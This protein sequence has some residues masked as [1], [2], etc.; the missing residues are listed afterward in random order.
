MRYDRVTRWLHA[1][2]AL[3]ITAQLGL[4]LFMHAPDDK[5]SEPVTGLP[6]QLFEIHEITGLALLGVLLAHW[7]WSVSGHVQGGLRHLFPWFDE[8][9]LDAVKRDIR[10]ALALRPG[11]PATHNALAGAV[12][13]LGLLLATAMAASGTVIYFNLSAS[14]HLSALA[15]VFL[16][17]HSLLAPV[18]WVYL[19]GHVAMAAIHKWQGHAAI[20]EI[21]SLF[22]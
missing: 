2:I 11:D 8:A 18:V 22:R 10:G 20:R 13:G 4:S 21:F 6:L 17:L 9:H 12:H 19:A 7:L 5:H 3:G 15:E 14:G 16:A 1:G